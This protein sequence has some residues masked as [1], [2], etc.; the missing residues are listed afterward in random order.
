MTGE[1]S[2]NFHG[3]GIGP[4]SKILAANS[5]CTFNSFLAVL[6]RN[7]WFTVHVALPK[8]SI[9]QLK[10]FRQCRQQGLRFYCPNIYT[11]TK[12]KVK[13]ACGLI[14]AHAGVL[15]LLATQDIQNIE[16]TLCLIRGAFKSYV[17][18]DFYFF[19]M[20]F[21][22]NSYYLWI[23]LSNQEKLFI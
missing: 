22:V 5:F 14:D 16:S 4:L 15:G 12:E 18:Y 8:W 23:V 6:A 17:N 19:E 2:K 11:V 10:P 20:F 1:L 13:V 7:K 9:N 21:L 3:V